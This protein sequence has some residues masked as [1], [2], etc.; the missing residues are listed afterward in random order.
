M[1]FLKQLGSLFGGASDR[2]TSAVYFTV[3]CGR[4][5]EVIRVRADKAHDLEE[6]YDTH[7]DDIS[8]YT[9]HKEVL[10][11]RCPRLLRLTVR[12][13]RARRVVAHEVEGGELVDS[14]D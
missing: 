7:A 12:F 8:G 14:A 9:L 5:G 11:Q 6:E 2:G 13:D 3:K 4:C 1:S 10:G